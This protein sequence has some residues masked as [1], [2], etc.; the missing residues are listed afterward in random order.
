MD[1]EK[2]LKALDNEN[3][4]KIMNLS[5]KKMNA[6]KLEILS[7]LNFSKDE[8]Y[9]YLSKLKNYRYID[10]INDLDIGRF[11]RWINISEPSN[12]YLNNGATIC[13]IKINDDGIFILVKTFSNK[14]FQI[15]M[16]ECLI[17]QKLTIQE[18]VILTALNH[19]EKH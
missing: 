6:M 13:D 5:T 1:I 14:H 10:E 15:K 12:I 4:S 11:I 3:N 2:L 19:L 17:F 9:S 18:E 8:L 16:D 7:E